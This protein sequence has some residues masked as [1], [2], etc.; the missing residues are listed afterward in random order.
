MLKWPWSPYSIAIGNMGINPPPFF[1]ILTDNGEG[2]WEES[3]KKRFI[4]LQNLQKDQ[5]LEV[6]SEYN[7]SGTL[8]QS[9]SIHRNDK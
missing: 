6:G 2:F 3:L 7:C 1:L 8:W 9:N 5:G 4:G